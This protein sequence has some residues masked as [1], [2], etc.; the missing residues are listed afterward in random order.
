MREILG[1]MKNVRVLEPVPT[2]RSA[3]TPESRDALVA[4]ARQLAEA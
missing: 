4:L 2:I 1:S 3:L